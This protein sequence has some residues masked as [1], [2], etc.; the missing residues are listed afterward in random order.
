MATTGIYNGTYFRLFHD[1]E[2][3]ADSTECTMTITAE[4][5]ETSSKDIVGGWAAFEPGQKSFTASTATLIR[6]SGNS[7]KFTT[8]K[9]I[10]GTK[11]DLVLGNDVTGDWELAG[12][13]WIETVS[14]TSTNKENVTGEFTFRGTGALTSGTT[15]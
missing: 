11:F 13:A 14:I 2:A 6:T 10:A 9:L 5:R 12:E 3:F 1:G 7:G 8:D 15:T 4:M